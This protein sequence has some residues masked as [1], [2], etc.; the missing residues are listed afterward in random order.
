MDLLQIYIIRI[1]AHIQFLYNGDMNKALVFYLPIKL[2][3]LMCLK[4]RII[5]RRGSAG[6]DFC[7]SLAIVVRAHIV[8]D[9]TPVLYRTRYT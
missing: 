9:H 5:Y 3:L 7:K 6:Y 8:E 2:A 4:S 1:T